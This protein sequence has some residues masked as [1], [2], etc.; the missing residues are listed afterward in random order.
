MSADVLIEATCANGHRQVLQIAGELGLEYARGL[1]GLLDGTSDLYR[2]PPD[3]KSVIGKC[4]ICGSQIECVV[5]EG[6]DDDP[7]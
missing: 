6:K 3:E 2:F 7:S 5:S 1:A 4:G